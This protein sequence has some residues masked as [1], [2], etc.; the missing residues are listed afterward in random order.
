MQKTDPP[1]V[2]SPAPSVI[3]LSEERAAIEVRDIVTDRVRISTSTTSVEQMVR[4]D[5]RSTSTGLVR[6]PVN[7]T[8]AAGEVP[9]VPRTEG[10]VTIIPIFEEVAVVELRLV[11]KE[12][13]H[14]RQRETT[15]TAEIPLTLRKQSV[16]IERDSDE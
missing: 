15:E 3:E 11:L 6:V 4:Q 1:G 2:E 10:D 5:L 8:L 9:P 14:V 16:T 13:L 7:R 12:E